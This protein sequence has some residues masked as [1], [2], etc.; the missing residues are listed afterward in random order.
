MTTTLTSQPAPA[1]LRDLAEARA[2]YE[3]FLGWPL[4]IQVGSRDLAL[5]V[6]A[7]IGAVSMPARLGARVR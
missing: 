4:S 6:G 5:V 2:R 7:R 3:E 1:W